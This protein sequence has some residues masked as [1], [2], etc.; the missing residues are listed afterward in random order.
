MRI[1]VL[2]RLFFLFFL[3]GKTDY[4]FAQPFA[5]EIAAF[6]KQD[7]IAFPPANAILFVGSSSFTMWKDVQQ[8]FPGYTII[9]RGFGGSSLTDLTGYAGDVI[10]PYKP[11]QIII[12]CGE[13]DFAGND[14]LFPAQVAERFFELFRLIRSRVKKV[15]IAYVS[16]KPSPSRAHL[17]PKFNVANIMIREFLKRKKHTAFIN[18]Y[19]KMLDKKGRPLTGIF[20]EDMLHMNAK[21]YA[22]WQPLIQKVLKN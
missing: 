16:M 20:L 19:H 7:S 12:Y 9:N 4:L 18:V 8:Y 11:K 13:N 6:K 14:S 21:G 22:I 17:M 5:G 10:F 1:P 3:A 15:H 2:F